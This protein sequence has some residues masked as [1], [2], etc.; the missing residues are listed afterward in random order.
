MLPAGIKKVAG[1]FEVGDAVEVISES[2]EVLGRGLVNF[3]SSELPNLIGKN[4]VKLLEEFWE[5]YDKEVIHRD[6][7]VLIDEKITR[8]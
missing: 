2:G 1:E 8:N 4:T 6:D 5:G 3:D 7:L